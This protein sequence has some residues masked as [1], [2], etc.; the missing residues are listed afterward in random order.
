M[1]MKKTKSGLLVPKEP[2]YM[3]KGFRFEITELKDYWHGVA[4]HTKLRTGLKAVGV[5]ENDVGQQL[6]I[7]IDALPEVFF[8]EN[9]K[10]IIE[11]A[12]KRPETVVDYPEN[13][14]SDNG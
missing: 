1:P 14:E 3:Y 4:V 13:K 9:Y 6:Q 11:R 2:D 12:N 7:L 10:N 8:S 5:S